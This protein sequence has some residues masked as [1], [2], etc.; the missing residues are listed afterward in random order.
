MTVDDSEAP[1]YNEARRIRGRAC[2]VISDGLLPTKC[3]RTALRSG[4]IAKRDILIHLNA[5]AAR[6]PS[7]EA[8]RLD[9]R[10]NN[11][12]FHT[13]ESLVLAYDFVRS[14]IISERMKNAA[15]IILPKSPGKPK[16]LACRYCSMTFEKEENFVKHVTEHHSDVVCS[17]C[18]LLSIR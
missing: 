7:V 17:I 12:R 13:I 3:I 18:I 14:R 11:A 8:L 15:K 1:D 5:Y 6:V 10:G 4:Y 9:Y 16:L 2:T